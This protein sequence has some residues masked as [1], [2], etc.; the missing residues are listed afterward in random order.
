[1]GNDFVWA[2]IEPAQ[3]NAVATATASLMGFARLW[4]AARFAACGGFACMAVPGMWVGGSEVA[5]AGEGECAVDV[6]EIGGV[7]VERVRGDPVTVE[8]AAGMAVDADGAPDA[9]RPGDTGLDRLAN[10][11]VPG[12]WWALA[13]DADGAPYVQREADPAPGAYVSTTSL[14][15]ERF[16][17]RDPRRYVDAARVPYLALPAAFVDALGCALGDLAWVERTARDGTVHRSAALFADVSPPS[18][19]VG[20]GSMALAGRLG[21]PTHPRTGGTRRASVRYVLFCGSRIG[22]PVPVEAIDAAADRLERSR[23]ERDASACPRR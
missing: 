8:F 5:F 4:L 13:T 19:P 16:E 22:W 6:R 12:S 18:A 7:R 20:E 1:L 2:G 15:D 21:I 14:V 3:T 9:Y 11:G 10:A 17:P 23:R